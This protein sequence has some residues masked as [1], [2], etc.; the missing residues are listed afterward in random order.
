M[1]DLVMDHSIKIIR[2]SNRKKTVSAKMVNGVMEVLAPAD[3]PEKELQKII[4]NLQERIQKQHNKRQL[5]KSEDLESRAQELN[6]RYFYGE[7]KIRSIV[8]VTNQQK[9][10]GSCT[11]TNGTIRISD[12][13][14]R[15]PKWV[16]D[17]VLVHELAHLKVPNHS[18]EFWE[19][20]NLYPLAERARGYLMA[21]NMSEDPPSQP[22]LFE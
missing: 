14:A 22:N 19:L 1:L 17:Y 20:V 21:I 18:K 2:S 4:K 9:R 3:I 6:R 12:A 10:L 15:L 13:V 16:S 8:Y 11:T 7:L 5:N